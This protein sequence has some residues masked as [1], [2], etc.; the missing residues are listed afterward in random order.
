VYGERPTSTVSDS[1]GD[2]RLDSLPAGRWQ[3][4]AESFG[5][6]CIPV[7]VKAGARLRIALAYR[8]P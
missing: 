4:E 3:L 6:R 8:A 5:T 1:A 2:F 7:V